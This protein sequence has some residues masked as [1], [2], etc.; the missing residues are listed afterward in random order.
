M[1]LP[2]GRDTGNKRE[3]L[4]EVA[5]SFWKQHNQGQQRLSTITRRM[6]QGL[7]RVFTAE[8]SEVIH[9]S[10]VTLGVVREA[11]QALKRKRS[12]GP[13]QLVAE[14]YQNLEAPEPDGLADRV[15]EVLRT[16]K[17]PAEW[18]GKV[19]PLY[20]KGGHLRPGT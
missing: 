6:V 3:V 8:E 17:P 20:K 11:V 5:Q 14:A 18:G 4:E 2:D 10:R 13:D 12:P 15:T 16:G 1:R 9:R 7:P 19:R